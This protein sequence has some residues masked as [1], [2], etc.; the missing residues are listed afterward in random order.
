MS[1]EFHRPIAIVGNLNVD[2]IVSTVTRFPEWDEELIVESSRV[3]LAGTA[4]YL[5]LAGRGFGMSPFVVS[6]VGDDANAA[7]LR[8]E[9]IA[10][11]I[12]TAGVA[13]IRDA[14]TCLG[15]VFVG[16]RGQR[17]ILTVLG[18]HEQMSVAVAERHD[19]RIAACAE[20]FLCGNFLLPQFSPGLV[21]GYARGLRQRGQFVVF[22]PSWDPGGWQAQ[23]CDDTLALLDHV[24]LFMPNQEELCHLTGTSTWEEGVAAI[25]SRARHT[26]IKR[27]ALGAVSVD[28]KAV[29]DVPGLP[30][31][32]ANTTGAGDVFD[33]SFIYG[34]RKGWEVR[35]C[36]EFACASAA[37]VVSQAGS[38]TYP[39]EHAVRE[40]AA[41]AI[42]G[43]I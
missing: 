8:R 43:A 27:G 33:M 21:T 9:L 24:D 20:V 30:I 35:Q 2:Q 29:I 39:D 26:V 12:D 38:R 7:F 6:T 22:D 34:R 23:T 10:A 3:E 4:G 15:I 32:A 14:A 25:G 41:K 16:D 36:L 40:F 1:Y 31:D 42:D 19:D 37:Y 11:G 18:A 28:G 5:A 17:S 13:T